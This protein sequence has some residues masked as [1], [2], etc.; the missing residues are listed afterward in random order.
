MEK[1]EKTVGR[2]GD[3]KN[4]DLRASL[5]NGIDPRNPPI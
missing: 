1:L 2:L 4:T 5:L 3:V